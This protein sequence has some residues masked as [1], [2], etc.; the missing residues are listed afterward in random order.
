MNLENISAI[1]YTVFVLAISA[2]VI[3]NFFLYRKDKKRRKRQEQVA[4]YR[5]Q[6]MRK[7]K[8]LKEMPSFDEM[9]DDDFNL[10]D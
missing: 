9:L 7:G 10:D 8:S 2:M 5:V 1:F 6:Q 3:I 4:N